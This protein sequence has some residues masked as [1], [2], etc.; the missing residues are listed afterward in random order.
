MKHLFRLKHIVHNDF[1]Y[2]TKF[3]TQNDTKFTLNLIILLLILN[4]I[5]VGTFF[6]LG[7]LGGG[8]M[9]LPMYFLFFY[10]FA[11]LKVNFFIIF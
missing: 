9:A 10:F 1:I 6:K 3:G 11:P 4:P 7:V 5:Q 2:I 8:H